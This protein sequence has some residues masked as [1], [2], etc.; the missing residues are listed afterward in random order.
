[1]KMQL[2]KIKKPSADGCSTVM[3]R[4]SGQ[5]GVIVMGKELWMDLRVG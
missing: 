2:A 5:M 1:M 3:L 4:I